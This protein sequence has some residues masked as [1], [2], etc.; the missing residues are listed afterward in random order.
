MISKFEDGKYLA[1]H[2]TNGVS[3]D[4]QQRQ[5]LKDQEETGQH[6]ISMVYNMGE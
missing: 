1:H 6:V 2:S 3:Y 4:R 5:I